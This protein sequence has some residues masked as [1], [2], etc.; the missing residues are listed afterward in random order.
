M[1]YHTMKPT[2]NLRCKTV[3]NPCCVVLT[4]VRRAIKP[5]CKH[6]YIQCSGY[7]STI[8]SSIS[9]STPS[10][11]W[12]IAALVGEGSRV[13]NRIEDYLSVELD[14]KRYHISNIIAGL[15]FLHV[16]VEGGAKSLKLQ[17]PRRPKNVYGWVI[18]SKGHVTSG[19]IEKHSIV[20]YKVCRRSILFCRPKNLGF[21]SKNQHG[22]CYSFASIKYTMKAKP[23]VDVSWQFLDRPIF[24]QQGCAVT[25]KK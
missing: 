14:V 25:F 23:L 15:H 12:Q 21:A 6:S 9:H 11:C 24:G 17:Q 5:E 13:G 18:V 4:N 10:Q 20:K 8:V 1:L 3:Q 19:K 7:G 22:Q 16:V 2:V